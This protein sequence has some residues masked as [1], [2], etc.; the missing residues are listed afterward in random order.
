MTWV[1][2]ILALMLL[3]TGCATQKEL[4]ATGGSRADGTVKLSF[5]YGLF[6]SP[7]LNTEQG[8]NVAS[9]RCLAWGYTK[10]EPFGGYTSN[11]VNP[12]RN[13]CTRWMVTIEYQ[14]IGT[15][16]PKPH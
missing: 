15:G 10:A 2:T 9:Q 16:N 13:G 8:L 5:E 6:E 14:C 3:T 12:S 7:K 4:I 11:C 1:K